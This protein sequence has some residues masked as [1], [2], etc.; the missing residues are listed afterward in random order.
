M[1]RAPAAARQRLLGTAAAP[2]RA[3]RAHPRHIGAS[4]VPWMRYS[5]YVSPFDSATLC[6]RRLS[7]R[8]R[9]SVIRP[10]VDASVDSSLFCAPYMHNLNYNMD[11]IACGRATC[12]HARSHMYVGARMPSSHDSRFRH[13]CL[14]TSR[15]IFWG[16]ASALQHNTAT[17][18]L[19]CTPVVGSNTALSCALAAIFSNLY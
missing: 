3:R 10:T 16:I 19:C 2:P 15:S 6:E 9:T 12:S 18:A 14:N 8:A 4:L 7:H 11:C 5:A 13:I 17:C 1:R